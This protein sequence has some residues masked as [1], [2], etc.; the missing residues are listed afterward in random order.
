MQCVR[1]LDCI[2]KIFAKNRVTFEHFFLSFV[3]YCIN[4]PRRP[5]VCYRC[6][7]VNSLFYSTITVHRE[8]YKSLTITNSRIIEIFYI[9]TSK[10]KNNRADLQTYT[11]YASGKI[12]LF[13]CHFKK[14]NR[15]ICHLK[16]YF[17]K[18]E[19]K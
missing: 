2:M 6:S 19:K 14:D 8:I 17:T 5:G 3:K 10:Q 15:R 11:F 12:V 18:K 1:S 16:I 9:R 13:S 4:Y 7:D